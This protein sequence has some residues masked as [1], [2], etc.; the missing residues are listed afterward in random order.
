MTD[1]TQFPG[2]PFELSACA[3]MLWRETF[4]HGVKICFA[5]QIA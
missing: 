3:E 5:L 2:D 1:Q 4:D